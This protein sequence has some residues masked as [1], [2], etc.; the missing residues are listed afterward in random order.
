M[1]VNEWF[2]RYRP[3]MPEADW[4]PIQ[5]FVERI[6][7]GVHEQ[8]NYELKYVCSAVAH[9]VNVCRTF[10][11]VELHVSVVFDLEVITAAVQAMPEASASQARRRGI[12]IRVAEVLGVVAPKRAVPPLRASL[13]S[14][15]YSVDYVRKLRSHIELKSNRTHARSLGVLAG[16]GFGAGL[17][18]G[19]IAR[20]TWADIHPGTHTVTAGIHATR[21]IPLSCEWAEYIFGDEGVNLEP[22]QYVFLP[23]STRYANLIGDFVR[24]QVMLPQSLVPQRMR[25]TWL[26]EQMQQGWPVMELLLI[27]G[28]VNLAALDRYRR[29][30]KSPTE[31][32]QAPVGSDLAHR[33][34][35]EQDHS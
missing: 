26:V 5:M 34:I 2:E 28:V 29:H 14:V 11:C 12:L 9:H 7:A 1:D 16:L 33:P 18:G 20:V 3:E 24:R 23:G 32:S 6:V 8:V 17:T 30:L 4:E 22:T 25:A 15:P 27:S 19:E 21:T 13:A 35:H 10:F 31:G